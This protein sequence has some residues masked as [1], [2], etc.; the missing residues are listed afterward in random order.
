M[1]SSGAQRRGPKD[2]TL[3]STVQSTAQY[4]GAVRYSTCCTV[5][6]SGALTN[7]LQLYNANLATGQQAEPFAAAEQLGS[8]NPR[9]RLRSVTGASKDTNPPRRVHG[10]TNPEPG[11]G[12]QRI[13]YSMG[14]I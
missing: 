14:R 8:S 10:A 5:Q 11:G 7:T 12:L 4:Y 2:A 13:L 3:Q 6:L 1:Q 9:A